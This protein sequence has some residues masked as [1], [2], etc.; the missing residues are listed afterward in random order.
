MSDV[1]NGVRRSCT[2][3]V[4]CVSTKGSEAHTGLTPRPQSTLHHISQCCDTVF[5]FYFLVVKVRPAA[6]TRAD[7]TVSHFEPRSA[8]SCVN[9]SK[10]ERSAYKV[11]QQGSWTAAIIAEGRSVCK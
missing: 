3:N 10:A 6:I 9:S 4:R 7:M 5:V 1:L 11:G 2:C 8:R